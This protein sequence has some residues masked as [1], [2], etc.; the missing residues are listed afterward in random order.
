V[1]FLN[2]FILFCT[3]VYLRADFEVVK[4]MECTVVTDSDAVC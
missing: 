4:Q 1:H 3:I 2:D